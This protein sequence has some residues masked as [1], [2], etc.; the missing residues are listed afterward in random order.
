MIADFPLRLRVRCLRV[1]ATMR[2]TSFP[3]SVEPVNEIMSTS[4]VLE[5]RRARAA[6]ARDHVDDARRQFGFLHDLREVKRRK[7]R[8]LR[9]LED[10]RVAG[11]QRRRQLPRSEQ[12]RE[13][14]RNDRADHAVR[15]RPFRAAHR[16]R[17]LVGPARVIEQVRRGAGDVEAAGLAD[18]FSACRGSP[19]APARSIARPARARS[20]RCTS[21]VPR[22]RILRQV[23][24]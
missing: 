20:G 1:P 12:Q 5:Q 14:R 13:I 6:V 11:G 23:L 18:R 17:Q 15:P 9:R 8:H 10:D 7:R 4:R 16:P 19:R 24:S 2:R 3:V 21:P 22:A